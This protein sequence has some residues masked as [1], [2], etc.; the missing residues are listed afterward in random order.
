MRLVCDGLTNARIAQCLNIRLA[1]VKT[2][3][4]HVFEKLGVRTRAELVGRC[5]S[6]ML[7]G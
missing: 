1:T 6:A 3:L 7:P 5:L 2:H 4:L